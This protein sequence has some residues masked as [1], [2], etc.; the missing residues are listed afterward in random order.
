MSLKRKN[1]P[2][3]SFSIFVLSF[4]RA[5][6]SKKRNTGF[7]HYIQ[8]KKIQYNVMEQESSREGAV[9]YTVYITSCFK[10]ISQAYKQF[11]YSKPLRK[12]ISCNVV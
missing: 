5:C 12:N 7:L 10:C 8:I 2:K 6:I 4:I 9:I 3:E 11:N 1:L